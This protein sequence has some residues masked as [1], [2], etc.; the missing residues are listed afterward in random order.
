[1]KRRGRAVAVAG[2]VA[3][4]AGCGGSSSSSRWRVPSVTVQRQL[5]G[6]LSKTDAI[7][8]AD[9]VKAEQCSRGVACRAR[10]YRSSAQAMG[11]IERTLDH[12]AALVPRT[13]CAQAAEA[14]RVGMPAAAAQWRSGIVVPGGAITREGR[15]LH[16]VYASCTRPPVFS[17]HGYPAGAIDGP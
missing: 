15:R 8:S 1:M 11:N 10:A 2:L 12:V 4:V 7:V 6:A 14:A 5:V 17:L 16:L 9:A 3:A 13:Y